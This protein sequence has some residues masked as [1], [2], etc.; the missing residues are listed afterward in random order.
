MTQTSQRHIVIS[1]QEYELPYSEGIMASR[2]MATGLAP[3]RA[4]HVA[5][6][7]EDRLSARPSER[8]L[9]SFGNFRKLQRHLKKLAVAHGVPVVSSD[10]L[11]ATLS[12]VIDLVVSQAVD[13]IPQTED[14]RSS[15]PRTKRGAP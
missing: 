14:P 8:Y 1:G 4:Y 11:D 2:I 6:V 15:V 5:Q 13:A 10:D 3:A 7:V 9:D 12:Q